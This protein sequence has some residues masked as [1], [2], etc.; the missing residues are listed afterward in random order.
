[1]H[2]AV[3]TVS[4]TPGMFSSV[5]VRAKGANLITIFSINEC[6]AVVELYTE[7]RSLEGNIYS[8]CRKICK[9][10]CAK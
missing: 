6:V 9:L 2:T 7:T 8:M 10:C 1:M 4:F 5:L 3:I